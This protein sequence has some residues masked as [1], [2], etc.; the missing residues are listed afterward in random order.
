MDAVVEKGPDESAF[1]SDGAYEKAQ[2]ILGRSVPALLVPRNAR[3]VNAF[4][5]GLIRKYER[6][7]LHR[8][9]KTAAVLGAGV[10]ALG[11]L[12]GILGAVLGRVK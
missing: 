10:V 1:S 4:L 7:A 12:G 5:D 6:Y 8:S 11:A 9:V 2:L 3:A